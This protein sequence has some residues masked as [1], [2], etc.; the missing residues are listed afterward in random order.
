MTQK[1]ADTLDPQEQKTPSPKRRMD[2]LAWILMGA[3]IVLAV[4]FL[5]LMIM[6]VIS[7]PFGLGIIFPIVGGLQ[8]LNATL[9]LKIP[10]LREISKWYTVR[11]LRTLRGIGIMQVVLGIVSLTIALAFGMISGERLW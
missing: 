6:G 11:Y 3:S 1:N 10:R 4:V 9:R 5:P 8:I 2:A 7:S